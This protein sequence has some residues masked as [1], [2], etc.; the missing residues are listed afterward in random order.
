MPANVET[1][2]TTFPTTFVAALAA[3]PGTAVVQ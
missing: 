3:E 2:S 1:L